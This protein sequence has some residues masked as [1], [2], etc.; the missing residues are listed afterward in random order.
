MPSIEWRSIIIANSLFQ[1]EYDSDEPEEIDYDSV[2]HHGPPS[3][4]DS[5]TIINEVNC[6]DLP[7]SR[8]SILDRHGSSMKTNQR[9]LSNHLTTRLTA[10]KHPSQQRIRE[11]PPLT[12]TNSPGSVQNSDNN[13]A[14][15][16]PD[17]P[18]SQDTKPRKRT[19]PHAQKVETKG[20]KVP[21]VN[22]ISP[23]G[24]QNY[25]HYQIIGLYFF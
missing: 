12:N 1:F 13:S 4:Q 15:E 6:E 8:Y 23:C 10:H 9:I 22:N 20:P 2:P 11:S 14:I 21:R 7:S 25:A 18:E 19:L 17:V 3:P 24:L 16:C 5:P